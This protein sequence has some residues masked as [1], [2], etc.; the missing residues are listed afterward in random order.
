MK[1]VS[2]IIL[3]IALGLSSCNKKEFTEEALQFNFNTNLS[4]TSDEIIVNDPNA[5][6]STYNTSFILDMNNSDAHQYI[7][8][9]KDVELSEITFHFHDLYAL[10]GN[11][12]ATNLS[13]TI[14]NQIT[15]DFPNFTYDSVAQGNPVIITDTSKNQQ[16]ATLLL[17]NKQITIEVN[18]TISDTSP[19]HFFITIEAKAKITATGTPNFMPDR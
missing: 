19:H 5:P 16:I 11:Q 4:T 7:N 18:G 10:A 2:L 12:T 9:L 8:R 3:F 14:N 15:F 17:Q 1:K 6:N 13:F